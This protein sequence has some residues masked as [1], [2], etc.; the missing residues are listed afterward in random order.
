MVT[1]EESLT[2]RF[3]A[4]EMYEITKLAEEEARPK[5]AMVRKLVDEAL[6]ARRAQGGDQ[7]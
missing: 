6:T 2:I 3:S 7:A 4:L 5:G 1:R